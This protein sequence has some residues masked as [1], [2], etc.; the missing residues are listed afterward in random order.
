MKKSKFCGPDFNLSRASVNNAAHINPPLKVH[1]FTLKTKLLQNFVNF[2][3]YKIS[4]TDFQQM[5]LI[6]IVNKRSI[7]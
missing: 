7:A 6:D 5:S 1:N 4:V 3:P 2:S